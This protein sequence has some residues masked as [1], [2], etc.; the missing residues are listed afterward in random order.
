MLKN[1]ERFVGYVNELKGTNALF[2]YN[3]IAEK[4]IK[5][6]PRRFE[7]VVSRDAGAI[8]ASS[9]LPVISIEEFEQKPTKCVVIVDEPMKFQSL[10]DIYKVM[11]RKNIPLLG[12]VR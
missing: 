11:Y 2:G 7:Y 10:D 1:L 6:F 4:L 5:K 12:G 3:E 9:M 8:G